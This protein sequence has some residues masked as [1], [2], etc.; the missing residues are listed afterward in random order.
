MDGKI[1]RDALQREGRTMVELAAYLKTTPQNLNNILTKGNI[2]SGIVEAAALFL[3]KPVNYFYGDIAELSDDTDTPA[4]YRVPLLPI[5][6]HAGSLTDFAEAINEYECETIV[7]PVRGASFAIQV[8]GDSMA[9]AYPSGAR[10]LCQRIDES[11]FIEWGK[12][13]LLDTVNGAVLK[14]VR[15][16]EQPDRVLCCSLNPAPEYAPFEVELRHI[17]AWFRIL[18]IMSLV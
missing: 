2:K 13:Y 18:M 16:S 3:N 15:K 11:A 8:T 6:A 10:I 14:Q 5:E 9:P 1:I 7:S 12:V 17:I 4:S